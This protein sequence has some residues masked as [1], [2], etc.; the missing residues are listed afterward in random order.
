[1]R[2]VIPWKFLLWA[3]LQV[4]DTISQRNGRFQSLVYQRAVVFFL[5]ARKLIV[6]NQAWMLPF[7]VVALRPSRPSVLDP[8]LRPYFMGIA[9]K[10]LQQW[11]QL[12]QPGIG[13]IYRM[14][15]VGFFRHAV[16]IP[17][18]I[19]PYETAAVASPGPSFEITGARSLYQNSKTSPITR[20]GP[21]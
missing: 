17:I 4:Y 15:N 9:R 21:R 14:R 19:E 6:G 13:S 18:A 5:G 16:G 3:G 10:L 7:R 20:Y 8:F 12:V 2:R 11:L 1:M